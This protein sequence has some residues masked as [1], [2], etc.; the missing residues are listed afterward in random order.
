MRHL[1]VKGILTFIGKSCIG[2]NEIYGDILFKVIAYS[3]L[4][5]IVQIRSKIVYKLFLHEE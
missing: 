3:I 5:K 1:H 4:L 2:S